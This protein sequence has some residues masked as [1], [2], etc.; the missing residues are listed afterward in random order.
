MTERM[1]ENQPSLN[2]SNVF[3]D[4]WPLAASWGLMGLEMPCI[5][6]VVGHLPE[7]E[8][9]LAA[10]GGIAFPLGLLVEAPIIMMLAAS[11]ALSRD[12]DSFRR[13]QRFMTTLALMLTALHALL[14]FTPLWEWLVIPAL[15]IPASV[16]NPARESFAWL[17]PWT[18][19]I[20]DRRFRQGL[21]IHFG[22][23]QVIV[24]G[25]GIRLIATIGT[26]T[27]L[28]AN[29]LPGATVASASLSIGVI[30]EAAYVRFRSRPVVS[31]PLRSSP[32]AEQPLVLRR[33]LKF[34][35]PLALTPIL[36][37]AAQP[38]GAAGM[39]R[40]PEALE[41]LAVWA[42]LGG[43]IFLF[44]SSGIAYNEVAIRLS[45][46]PN[47]YAQLKRFAWIT[48]GL[49][50]ML[51]V[52]LAA[53]PLS[54]FWFK[55]V[56]GLDADLAALGTKAIWLAVPIPLL[57]FLQSLYQGFLV[58]SHQTRPI[59]EAVS[60]YLGLTIAGMVAGVL[61]GGLTGLYVAL[62][63]YSAANLGQT[64]WL[65]IRSRHLLRISPLSDQ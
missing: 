40:M 61:F 49:F 11:T 28:A 31:G 57:T 10:F 13:L 32:P 43:L 23:K 33:L 36:I 21:L 18:W 5:S 15:D 48:G 60:C 6:V 14:A 34:Y 17:L 63:T 16:Q 30:V 25:T 55:D 26:L 47:S 46:R 12:S 62:L 7:A 35:I 54:S 3:H 56:V 27:I 29:E 9:M 8:T 53:S 4:W 41:S 24:F 51:L 2:Q 37:L 22:M 39:T 42:P 64:G 50:S 52:I 58:N 45:D 1:Q 38:I 19:A 20:A 44:R 65:Y 59:T